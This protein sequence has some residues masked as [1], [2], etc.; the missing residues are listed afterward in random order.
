[1]S[2]VLKVKNLEVVLENTRFICN[3]NKQATLVEKGKLTHMQAMGY[4]GTTLSNAGE[5]LSGLQ[6]QREE[7][8][9]TQKYAKL[10]VLVSKPLLETLSRNKSHRLAGCQM[11]R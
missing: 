9:A 7:S 3:E 5:H 4:G 10:V 11:K 8:K 6:K 2:I 1:M